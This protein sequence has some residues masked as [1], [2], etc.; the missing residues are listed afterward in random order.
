MK[1]ILLFLCLLL[2]FSLNAQVPD[3]LGDPNW[4]LV[5]NVSDEF[6]DTLINDTKWNWRPP[7]GTFHGQPLLS[8]ACLTTEADNRRIQD[9]ILILSATDDS[10]DC[11]KWDGTE[12]D[13]PYTVG[14]MYSKNT[15][16][17]GYFEIKIKIPQF[18]TDST[19]QGFGPNFWMW[20]LS[21]YSTSE[22]GDVLWSEI[23]FF[24]IDGFSN[25]F[26]CNV[27]YQEL[28]GLGGMPEDTLKWHLREP[29][30]FGF[31]PNDR[32]E[33]DF[34][35][36]HIFSCAW[37]PDSITFYVDG[38]K[39][40][41]TE[42]YPSQLKPMNIL[43]D[44]NTPAINFGRAELSETAELPY[45]YEIDY[46]RVYQKKMDCDNSINDCSFLFA[47]Y[48]QAYKK[49]ITIGDGGCGNIQPA[50]TELF[51]RAIEEVT[52]YGEFGVP[53]GA[54]LTIE[55]NVTCYDN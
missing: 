47:G 2:I 7:W 23:D 32:P 22:I 38:E 17:Y 33:M 30:E 44:I 29:D 12:Y 42:N 24:E 41:T 1:V 35:T 11:F 27:H 25:R 40:V 34:S 20:P 49:N 55:T 14:A 3:V 18:N 51:L 19:T 31:F 46:I 10:S 48:D 54:E 9:G 26:T 15:V 37:D 45:N 5:P 43:I 16:K 4:E 13:K 53:L 8:E 39:I 50:D 28:L 6:N 36:W 52:I 21:P